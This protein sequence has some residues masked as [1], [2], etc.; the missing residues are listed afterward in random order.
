[1]PMQ[2]PC[3]ALISHTSDPSFEG[4]TMMPLGGLRVLRDDSHPKALY[5][6]LAFASHPSG[7]QR[8]PPS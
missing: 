3:L 1:M 7:G 6:C 2:G 8:R 4:M 5:D